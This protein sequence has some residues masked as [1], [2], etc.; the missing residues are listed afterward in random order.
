MYRQMS[1]LESEAIMHL[2]VK[3]DQKRLTRTFEHFKLCLVCDAA[4]ALKSGKYSREDLT[5]I[6]VSADNEE[7][8]ANFIDRVLP[9][10][11]WQAIRRRGER[12]FVIGVAPSELQDL[13][14]VTFPMLRSMRKKSAESCVHPVIVVGADDECLVTAVNVPDSC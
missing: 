2:A 12:P 13:L 4:L 11:D 1:D 10:A 9:R 6:I 8:R 7:W 5:L 14:D 3:K